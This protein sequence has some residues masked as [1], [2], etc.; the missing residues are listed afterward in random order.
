MMEGGVWGN[1]FENQSEQ[2]KTGLWNEN[3]GFAIVGVENFSHLPFRFFGWSNK[4]HMR[5]INE[6][7]N[8]FN[9]VLME[10]PQKYKRLKNSQGN[11]RLICH[12]KLRN[13]RGS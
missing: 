1:C 12:P 9:F 13:G 8:K 10:A 2:G 5:Q 7:K 6:K 3:V 11:I 4:I